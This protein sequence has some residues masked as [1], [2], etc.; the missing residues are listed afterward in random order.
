MFVDF[1]KCCYDP[2]EVLY[3]YKVLNLSS[4]FVL[5][6]TV[7]SI[8]PS[9]S[10]A[11]FYQWSRGVQI[12][13]NLDLLMD[14][15]QS[16]GL[17]DLATEFFQKLSAAVNLL[18]TPKETLLQVRGCPFFSFLFPVCPPRV[19][20]S[21][22]RHCKSFS[23]SIRYSKCLCHARNFPSSGNLNL[24]SPSSCQ[25]KNPQAFLQRLIVAKHC[26]SRD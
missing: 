4:V 19:E 13:A 20:S 5:M 12:R 9:G 1:K 26:D 6:L 22:P 11:G 14:W 25:N 23:L 18:A 16:I 10:E 8:R 24:P 15:V 3:H 17:G 21:C 7:T 2:V